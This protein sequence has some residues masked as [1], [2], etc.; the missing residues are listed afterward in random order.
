MA[1]KM[2]DEN[3]LRSLGPKKSFFSKWNKD[4]LIAFYNS[5][6][7]KL[8][9]YLKGHGKLTFRCLKKLLVFYNIGDPHSLDKDR[10]YIVK[11]G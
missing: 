11:E 2:K 3:D 4:K 10:F 7:F 6:D 9:L 5:S 1:L 8:K